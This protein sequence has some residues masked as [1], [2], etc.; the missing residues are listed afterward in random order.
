MSEDAPAHDVGTPTS[1]PPPE[2][3]P[4]YEPDAS[5]VVPV[6]KGS[7]GSPAG[8]PVRFHGDHPRR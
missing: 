7:E 2:S 4:P 1:V 5:I 6:M 3:P 8:R